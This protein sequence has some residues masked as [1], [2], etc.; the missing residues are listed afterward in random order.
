MSNNARGMLVRRAAAFA[1][2]L[3]LTLTGAAEARPAEAPLPPSVVLTAGELPA[4]GTPWNEVRARPRTGPHWSRQAPPCWPG[5]T[6]PF[7]ESDGY[8]G[9]SSAKKGEGNLGH[10]LDNTVLRFPYRA[11][12]DAVLAEWRQ[13]IATCE[14]PVDPHGGSLYIKNVRKVGT[15]SGVDVWGYDFG[16]SG[17]QFSPNTN[18]LQFFVVQRENV[19][20]FVALVD[21]VTIEPHPLVTT[22]AT[23]AAVQRRLAALS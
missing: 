14:I 15:V 6:H 11:R 18:Y 16:A 10:T 23:I 2:V 8:D 20:S 21:H 7:G 9:A 19:L 3:T 12:A 4:V 13:R 22:E 5:V 1:A 17:Y